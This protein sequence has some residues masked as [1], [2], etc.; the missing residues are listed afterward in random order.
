[1]AKLEKLVEQAC[2]HLEQGEQIEA[3]VQGAYDTKLAGHPTVR[4]GVLLATDRRLLFFA[5]KLGG[6]DLESFPYGNISSFETSKG[7][8]G[9]SFRF[10]ASGNDVMLKWVNAGDIPRFI[11]LVRARIGQRP[12]AVPAQAAADPL[13]QLRKLAELRDA[14]IVTPEEFEAKKRQLLGL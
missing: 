12:A 11:E 13:D 6:H 4:N 5:K 3:A 7:M 8:M 2:P 9:H 1:M 10:A 14:G